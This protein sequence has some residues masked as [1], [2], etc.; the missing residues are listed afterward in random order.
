MEQTYLFEIPI[1][2]Y[3][4]QKEVLETKCIYVNNTLDKG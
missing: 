1:D 4:G 3:K 2:E